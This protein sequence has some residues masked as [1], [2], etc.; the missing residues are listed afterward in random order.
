MSKAR[1]VVL[2]IVSGHLS[3]SAAA[4]TY[5]MSR[6]HIHRLLKRFREGGLEAVDPRSRR[7]A[8]NPRAVSDEVITAIVL[9]REKLTAQGLDA[10]PITLQEHL[11]QQQLPVPST[12]TIRR[13]LHHHGLIAPQPHKRPRSSYHRFAAEQPNE[14]WQSDFTHWTLADGTDIEILNWLDD[15]SR[16]LLYC[17][18]FTRVSGP[19]IVASFTTLIDIYGPPA[20]TLTDNGS[21]YTSRFTHGHN[22]FERLIASLGITQKNGRPG[23]PQT[24]GKIERF[25]QTLKRWLA[26]RPRPS[27]LADLQHLLDE[28]RIIY[29]T[30]RTHRALPA[31]TTPAQA[32]TGRPKATPDAMI[33][34]FRIRHDTVDQ[35]G[36]LTLRHGS[37]LHHLGIGRRHA[38][39]PVLIVVTTTN[40]TIISKTGYHLIAGH[41]INPD[42]NYWPNQ[43]KTPAKRPGNSVTDDSTHV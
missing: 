38:H 24:Q 7:P 37:R 15:H 42:R 43:Q 10:G 17:T 4:R 31:A 2:E 28:F 27:T 9:L 30:E 26:A 39:T 35:F 25:H 6:Q 8:S 20:S 18:A 22:D 29:N 14:C 32:Y 3:V 36:K 41:R 34:H 19:D 23:H 16:Y 1:V 40:V 33:E 21:V 12:S 13:I 5:G 11:A